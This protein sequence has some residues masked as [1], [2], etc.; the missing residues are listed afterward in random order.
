MSPKTDVNDET[1]GIPNTYFIYCYYLQV[2]PV[3]VGATYNPIARD[4][5]HRHG[6]GQQK[7]SKY[8]RA[9]G[10]E[11]F[12]FRLLE[13]IERKPGEERFLERVYLREEH[14]ML[15]FET[16]FSFGKGG[17]NYDRELTRHLGDKRRE[18]NIE[19]QMEKL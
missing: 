8:I 1:N 11:K 15:K 4:Y 19:A 16:H 13:K 2:A 18:E 7:F 17:Q 6:G 3:Y 12:E 10:Q 9:C 5:Q 14:W